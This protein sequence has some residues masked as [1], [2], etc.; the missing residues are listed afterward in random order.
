MKKIVILF[1]FPF[2]V[3]GQFDVTTSV[4]NLAGLKRLSVTGPYKIVTVRG[5][6]NIND[7]W[8]GTFVYNGSSI[9]SADD[10]MAVQPNIGVC[11]WERQTTGR[12]YFARW[13][14]TKRTNS[15][16]NNSITWVSTHGGGNLILD[17]GQW[18]VKSDDNTR[19]TLQSNVQ[20]MTTA[21]SQIQCAPSPATNWIVVDFAL[22]ATNCGVGPAKIMGWNLVAPGGNTN[23]TGVIFNIQTTKNVTIGG[24]DADNWYSTYSTIG[25]NNFNLK[26]LDKDWKSTVLALGARGD[27]GDDTKNLQQ[28]IYY[29]ERYNQKVIFPW[30]TNGYLTSSIQIT[31]GIGLELVG[32]N[33]LIK[34]YYY[35]PT[36]GV[37]P[38]PS[39]T[40]IITANN[41]TVRGFRFQ[42]TGSYPVTETNQSVTGFF[43]PISI[44][45]GTNNVIEY[46]TFDVES[47]K[48]ISTSGD[49][50]KIRYN[51]FNRCGLTTG[52][53]NVQDWLFY[54][55]TSPFKGQKYSPRNVAI[56]GNT[57]YRGSPYKHTLFCSSADD[58]LIDGN[59]LIDINSPNP[60]LVYSGDEGVTDELG[61]NIYKFSGKIINNTIT[62]TNFGANGA[63]TLRLNTPTN[64]VV[65]TFFPSNM[66]SAFIIQDNH[67]ECTG[68][69]NYNGIEL[70]A[71]TGTKILGND[72]RTTGCPIHPV[73]NSDNIVI[74]GNYFQDSIYNQL[75]GIFLSEG[76]EAPPS[77][78]GMNIMNNTFVV[79]TNNEYWFRN[80]EPIHVENLTLFN[81]DIYYFGIAGSGDPP[82]AFQQTAATGYMDLIRNR[83]YI[84]NS[85]SGR[86][87][88]AIIGTNDLR[89]RLIGNESIVLNGATVN[90]RGFAINTASRVDVENNNVGS[91]EFNGVQNLQFHNNDVQ[92]YT[93]AF[94]SLEINT[95]DKASITGNNFTNNSSTAAVMIWVGATNSTF[96]DNIVSGN[97]SSDLVRSTV[98]KMF[99]NNNIIKNF[100]AGATFPNAYNTGTISH[101]LYEHLF[102]LETPV[103]ES[104]Y[105]FQAHRAG[106]GMHTAIHLDNDLTYFYSWPEVTN[107]YGGFQFLVHDNNTPTNTF[108]Y[109][110]KITGDQRLIMG[111]P[112][113][114]PDTFVLAHKD[115]SYLRVM[116]TTTTGTVDSGVV[117]YVP[118]TGFANS[119]SGSIFSNSGDLTGAEQTFSKVFTTANSA[120]FSKRGLYN[121]Q[122]SDDTGALQTVAQAN[123][124]KSFTVIGRIITG[125]G[126]QLI[127]GTGNPET[128][129]PAP[130]GS[131]FLRTD[132]NSGVYNKT[133]GT[134]STG[135]AIVGAGGGGTGDVVGPGSGTDNQMA[136][137]SGST[138]KLLKNTS[139]WFDNGTSLAPNTTTSSIGSS[140]NPVGLGYFLNTLFLGTN[141]MSIQ[142]VL[143]SPQGVQIDPSGSIRL[144]SDGSDDTSLYVKVSDD[145]KTTNW[146][147]IPT[148]IYIPIVCSDET[149]AL[150]TGVG[151]RTKRMLG[152]GTLIGIR[153]SLVTAQTSG[154]IFTVDFNKNG[155]TCLSTKI[156]IDNTEKTSLTAATPAVIS[157]TSFADDDE[158]SV[159]IDGVGDGTAAGLTVTPIFRR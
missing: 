126:A 128:V 99:V 6:T 47:G 146:A 112:T 4:T 125:T 13:W 129:V 45:I 17:G 101:D 153:A 83:F 127:S 29:A 135:W 71:G 57:F 158:F 75:G 42:T 102:H 31:N 147:G 77:F 115:T 25:P 118:S 73:G 96:S 132:G 97:S 20:L 156:T 108:A 80:V 78:K 19:V 22:N 107:S 140:A 100:G 94:Y 79:S 144:R 133:N 58:V 149:T 114:S 69:T 70:I 18:M 24:I 87:V 63:L 109:G 32:E 33:T 105:I 106:S 37:L 27:G 30:T 36:E 116:T 50:T 68:T 23:N 119:P 62:G 134:S 148:L 98:G 14:D 137:F 159:D 154:S 11:C 117:I 95:T 54:E 44:H 104:G 84:T 88:G 141:M 15:T 120:G 111:N 152:A 49:F 43:V 5:K 3:W 130:V 89:V 55:A 103:S 92:G 138:G 26:M 2:T 91:F 7:G 61:T 38:H 155:V 1:L 21:D 41:C 8:Q 145:T 40:F 113:N 48:G 76:F 10:S 52:L 74:N 93:N 143:G 131:L 81:N 12:D 39:G 122:V 110:L 72:V 60:L 9:L 82:M 90:R 136:L 123:Y 59:K 86:K 51:H 124:D 46:N 53:G 67:I 66:F 150:T 157:V 121:I 35:N 28:A 142:W 65:P 16:I 56:I 85:L 151:K 139:I 64:Y 34:N